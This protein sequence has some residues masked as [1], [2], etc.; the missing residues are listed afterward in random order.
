MVYVLLPASSVKTFLRK[1]TSL[2]ILCYF[3]DDYFIIGE[4][5][6]VSPSSSL[7][8]AC[9]NTFCC[10]FS[11]R[12]Y[13][14]QAHGYAFSSVEELLHSLGG[15]GFINMTRRSLS[16]S[17]LEFGRL[18]AL[19]WWSHRPDHEGQLRPEHQ[20]PCVCWYAKHIFIVIRMIR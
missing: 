5:W 3:T 15:S 6:R 13:K 17:L 1:I 7:L 18:P 8:L 9:F 14:Y 10:L 19:H 11:A 12:I 4:P 2:C 20:H 16:E